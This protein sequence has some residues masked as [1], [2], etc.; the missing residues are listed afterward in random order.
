MLPDYPELPVY[1]IHSGAITTPGAIEFQEKTGLT[2]A[3]PMP[4]TVELAAATFLWLTARNAEFLT[5]R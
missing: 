3:I 1:A 4:D 5:G 2:G